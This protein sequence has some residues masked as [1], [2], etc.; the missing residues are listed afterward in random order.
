MKKIILII[1]LLF[2]T[3]SGYC[4]LI[5][6][7]K[8]DS[9]VTISMP[10][11]YQKKDTSGEQIYSANGMYGYMIAFREANAKNNTPLK[12]QNDLNKVLKTYI[13]GIEAQSEGSSAQNVRDT[14]IGTLIAKTFTLKI[15]DGSGNIEFRNFVLLYTK[16]VTYTFEYVY[17]ADRE[18]IVND[19]YKAFITSIKLSPGLER[20]DQ[21]LSNATGMSPATRNEIIGGAAVFVIVILVFVIRRRRLAVA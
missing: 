17:P 11:G 15:D 3:I 20:N 9:L 8:L 10:P 16:D 4:Q 2:F 14:T 1:A 6:P 21:Y 18:G 5:K 19:E 12:R 13:K 7:V